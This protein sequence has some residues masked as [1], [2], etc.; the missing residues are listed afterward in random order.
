MKFVLLLMTF[1]LSACVANPPPN[2][3]PTQPNPNRPMAIHT[4]VPGAVVWLDGAN[5][6]ELRGTTDANGNIEFPVFPASIAAF[7]IH[8]TSDKFPQYGAV[9]TAIPSSD[10]LIVILGSCA[11]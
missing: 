6:P 1:C 9:I 8:A 10:P 11:K 3:V 2:G 4:C 7:N 5:V